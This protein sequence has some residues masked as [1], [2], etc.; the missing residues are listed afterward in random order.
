MHDLIQ[1]FT[2]QLD[3]MLGISTAQT[4]SPAESDPAVEAALQTAGLLTALDLAAEAA[5]R[6]DLRQR[7]AQSNAKP[8]TVHPGRSR[9]TRRLAWVV[10]LIL[11]LAL[12]AAFRQPVLAAVGRLF[13]YVYIQDS[14]FLPADSTLVLQQPVMQ[15]HNGLTLTV[16]RAV[17]TPDG[18]TLYLEFS[19]TAS[20]GDGATLETA[21]GAQQALSSWEY[22]PNTPGSHGLKL[23]FPPLPAGSTQT[24]L[25]LPAGW[26]LPLTWIP[27][28]RSGL[29]DVR[30]IPYAYATQSPAP[31]ADLCV[32]KH[33]VK[34]CLQAATTATDGTSV[35]VDATPTNPAL[36][37]T[38]WLQGLIW[39]SRTD[40]VTLK[41]EQGNIYPLDIQHPPIEGTLFFPPLAGKH[42]LTLTIPA[43]YASAVIPQQ[44]L[45]VD[46]GADPHPGDVIPLDANIQVLGATVH[47]SKATFIGD[48][49]GSLRLTLNAD[50]PIQM[51]DGLTPEALELGRPAR[52][53]DLYGGGALVDG[54]GLFVEL[55]QGGTKLTGVL[56]LPIVSATVI[57]Q[58]PF[59][60]TFNLTDLPALT[61]T[62]LV[63]NPNVF[64]PAPSS[65]PMSLDSYA[66]NGRKLES[67][68]LLYTVIDGDKTNVFAYTPAAGSQA[69]LVAT[70]PGAVAQIYIHPDRLGLDYLAGIQGTKDGTT[71][72]DSMSLYTLR[73]GKTTPRLLYN[74][75]PNSANLVGTSVAGYWSYDGSFVVFET[76]QTAPGSNVWKYIWFDLSCRNGAAC[77][78]HEI[79]VSP[80][81]SLGYP[82]FA[83][84]DDR[85]LFTGLDTG[86]GGII[87]LFIAN[88]DPQQPA[89]PVVKI[90]SKMLIA[91]IAGYP[92]QWTP[93]GKVL[94]GCWDG[95]SPET[96]FFCKIDPVSGAASHGG[97]I[98]RIMAGYRPYGFEHPLSP[99]GDQLL[100]TLFP[101]NS[102]DASI[103]DLR[104]LNLDGHLGAIVASS[105]SISHAMF[106]PSGQSIAY[107]IDDKPRLVIYDI[108]TGSHITVFEGNVPS[109]LTWMGWVP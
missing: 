95:T 7:W 102:T 72:I 61:P 67:G 78:P 41:D 31:A 91:D 60:F 82:T 88:I 66:Y 58:G 5:P 26:R 87:S 13:G 44:E 59:T 11:A 17:S 89:L 109:A 20:S 46:V 30:A 6:P 107:M 69:S 32:E 80:G 47:F 64:S 105:F 106:S 98:S 93:D 75:S 14:G 15:T 73:F 90:P 24:T 101:N 57:V 34:L 96:D 23:S 21:A 28:A 37:L 50:G 104:L 108:P 81:F 103:P 63:A 10:A 52:V 83:P 27:A 40:P 99:S 77:S 35:L 86:I 71:Y 62:P 18:T 25:T 79:V 100:Y 43:V 36:G 3:R 49:V 19:A 45:S 51:V 54:K 29:P 16:T 53:D 9:L 68:D 1:Q 42:A 55:I 38:M 74:F 22:L 56:D 65:T 4:G 94:S 48:G 76:P 12:L 8:P 39:Q 84:K 97:A 85:I 92:A 70:L 33:G 2:L